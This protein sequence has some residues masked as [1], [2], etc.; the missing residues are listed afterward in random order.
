MRAGSAT[1]T[2]LLHSFP[3]LVDNYAGDAAKFSI[4]TRGAGGVVIRQSS[5]YQ[6]EGGLNNKPG[7]FEWIVDA[8]QVTH[9][10]FIPNGKVTGF[11]NQISPK[12]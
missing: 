7:V 10:R 11:P 1:K 4:P 6:V 12:P 3:N 5:L 8:G 2:D 9:R